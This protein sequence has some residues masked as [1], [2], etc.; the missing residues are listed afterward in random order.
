M[1]GLEPVSVFIKVRVDAGGA[2]DDT[3]RHE[4]NVFRVFE[5]AFENA[6][7]LAAAPGD[8]ETEAGE[9]AG[10]TTTSVFSATGEVV[11][12]LSLGVAIGWGAS[13]G[14]AADVDAMSSLWRDFW[15][16]SHSWAKYILDSALLKRVGF[17]SSNLMGKDGTRR[18]MVNDLLFGGEKT[19]DP[20]LRIL[21]LKTQIFLEPASSEGPSA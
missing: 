19:A 12:W 2:N 15:Y 16:S 20:L 17:K 6:A 21:L 4:G 9:D 13:A 3:G 7:Q 1:G 10:A 18:P 14:I 5:N 11:E 8:G